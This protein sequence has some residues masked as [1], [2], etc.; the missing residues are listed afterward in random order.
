MIA[1][2]TLSRPTIS[3][4]SGAL[5]LVAAS[6]FLAGVAAT[7]SLQGVS[8]GA[9]SRVAAPQAAPTLDAVK[10]RAEERAGSYPE[11]TFDAVKFRAEEANIGLRAT[12]GSGPTSGHELGSES[13]ASTTVWE[14]MSRIRAKEAT[15]LRATIG[16]G[17]TSGN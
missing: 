15:S 2:T 6:A 16:T 1:A 14:L 9:V 8:Q 7:V 4:A 10:F 12:V 11:P 3:R 5:A 13:T 17:P